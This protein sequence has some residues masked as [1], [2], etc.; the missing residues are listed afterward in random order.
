MAALAGMAGPVLFT[1]TLA[2]LTVAQYDFMRGIGWRPIADPAGAWP[3][4][5][6]L[7]PYGW[8]QDANFAVSGVLLAVFAVGLHHG[9]GGGSRIGPILLFVTGAA[10]ALMAFET[11]PI[12]RTGPRTLHGWVHDAA[13]ALFV[14]ALLAALFFLWRGMRV[15]PYWR[16]YARYTLATGVC[17]VLLLLLPGMAY[18]LF[19]AVVLVWIGTTGRKLWIIA[20]RDDGRAVSGHA[21]FGL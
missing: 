9:T 11:D 21:T 7:G 10:M 19:L 3:S 12:P 16:G 14:L 18:Y 5:L 8:L 15:E 6:A 1:V 20:G 2:A 17:A 13:F 4:G